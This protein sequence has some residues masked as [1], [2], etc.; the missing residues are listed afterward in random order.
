MS[1]RHKG[2]QENRM[3]QLLE[4]WENKLQLVEAVMN[5]R[6][7]H[8]LSHQDGENLK[9]AVINWRLFRKTLLSRKL[10][11]ATSF[12]ISEYTLREY[13]DG[14]VTYRMI[15]RII[16]FW[17]QTSRRMYRLTEDMQRSLELTQ[18]GKVSWNDIHPPFPSFGL[19]LPI[20][21]AWDFEGKSKPGIDFVYAE[22]NAGKILIMAL[23]K[24]LAERPYFTEKKSA[25]IEKAVRSEDF[26]GLH[27]LL[28]ELSSKHFGTPAIQVVVMDHNDAQPIMDDINSTFTTLATIDGVSKK[29]QDDLPDYWKLIIRMVAGL[30]LHLET[31]SKDRSTTPKMRSTPWGKLD[32]A[33]REARMVTSESLICSVDTARPLSP[34][35]RK[36]HELIRSVGVNR[37]TQMAVHFRSAHWRK[38][39]GKGADP[40]APKCVHVDWA[41]VNHHL[42]KDGCAP[43]ASM[44]SVNA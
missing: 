19:V 15:P 8:D 41:V 37:A 18:I 39:P 24:D 33:L 13:L 22:F 42:L 27:T 3:E 43:V 20:P 26:E 5:K 21:I 25:A 35:E 31:A 16:H 32:P 14:S 28:T 12:D 29:T 1:L 2:L 44:V 38:K 30:C 6:W 40:N 11:D 10:S 23:S 36:M 7:I 34:E 9:G 17:S 4:L